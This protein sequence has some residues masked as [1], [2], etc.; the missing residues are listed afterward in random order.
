MAAAVGRERDALAAE[1]ARLQ[2]IGSF[3]SANDP[4]GPAIVQP[5][6][7]IRAAAGESAAAEL[8]ARSLQRRP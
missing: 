2:R 1:N 3:G 5:R 6:P 8:R 4:T 7:G